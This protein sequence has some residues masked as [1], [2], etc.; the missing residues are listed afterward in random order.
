M[1]FLDSAGVERFRMEGYLSREEFSAQLELALGRIA[2]MHKQ[3]ADAESWYNDVAEKHPGTASVAEA[4]YWAGV[5]YYKRTSDH[6]LLG[7]MSQQL[8]A[9]FPESI[10]TEKASVW[11]PTP[12]Q[13][14]T[15]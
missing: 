10:W 2:F 11:L 12:A 3:W 7:R 6:T 13:T 14:K 5:S 9:E 15:A 4:I 1:V 8:A